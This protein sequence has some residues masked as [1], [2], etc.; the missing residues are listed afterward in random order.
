MDVGGADSCQ[1]YLKKVRPSKWTD[2]MH[3]QEQYKL[4]LD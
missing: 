4:C 3:G 1:F 2:A